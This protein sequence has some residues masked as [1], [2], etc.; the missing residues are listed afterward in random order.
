MS[1]NNVTLRP[2][3]TT[4]EALDA[5]LY[6]L[7]RSIERV[8]SATEGMATRADIEAIGKRLDGFATK[9]DLA[10]LEERVVGQSPGNTFDRML[11][12]VTRVGAALAVLVAIGGGIAVVVHTLDR[13]TTISTSTTTTTSGSASK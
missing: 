5:H 4:I 12:L 1:D 2:P 13:A 3:A 8:V 6:H 9:G 10:E 11:S 7:Q